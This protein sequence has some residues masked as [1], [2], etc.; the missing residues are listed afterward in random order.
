MPT[1]VSPACQP[2]CWTLAPRSPS[3]PPQQ[4]PLVGWRQSSIAACVGRGDVE[5]RC[6]QCCWQSVGRGHHVAA[7]GP[8]CWHELSPGE[9]PNLGA[10]ISCPRSG[11]WLCGLHQ[12]T[13]LRHFSA[14][15][16]RAQDQSQAQLKEGCESRAKFPC[17][18]LGPGSSL[19]PCKPGSCKASRL[20]AWRGEKW[21]PG[22]WGRP[23]G[24]QDKIPVG[25]VLFC[26]ASTV[27]IP[28][29]CGGCGPFCLAGHLGK[30]ISLTAVVSGLLLLTST[31]PSHAVALSG[32]GGKGRAGMANRYPMAGENPSPYNGASLQLRPG[33]A[34]TEPS[35]TVLALA[36]QA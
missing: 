4:Q 31:G 25:W 12:P 28:K 32:A 23:A 5:P 2:C 6:G 7:K 33:Q 10:A 20:P 17:C 29:Q 13:C 1:A 36:V 22:R 3:H 14:V 15:V 27:V 26:P 8:R 18:T 30:A 9:R 16:F 24:T 11:F 19:L 21:G 35:K 34:L